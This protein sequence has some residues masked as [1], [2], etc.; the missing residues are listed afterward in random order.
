[1]ANLSWKTLALLTITLLVALGLQAGALK[2]MVNL[3]RQTDEPTPVETR[4]APGK[5]RLPATTGETGRQ[6]APAIEERIAA[7]PALTG[8][9]PNPEALL[10]DPP[11]LPVPAP[12]PESSPGSPNPEARQ[13]P[14]AAPS[15]PVANPPPAANPPPVSAEATNPPPVASPTPT[16]PVAPAVPV[17]PPVAAAPEVNPP[18][19]T[20]SGLQ[21]AAWIKARD[22]RR[23]TVQVYSGKNMSALREISVAVATADPQAYF[24]TTSRSGPWHS[25]VIG[26]YADSAAAQ[27]AAAKM[28]ARLPTMKPWVRRFDEVQA[29]LR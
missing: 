17:A 27:A 18:P 4:A 7:A 23:Y 13:L 24:T 19:A 14:G 25:L 28:T 22:P 5:P 1:M 6:P 12:K 2:I 8:Q 10:A 21:E 9:E 29:K 20:A 16:A 26:D 11:H 15:T 3:S